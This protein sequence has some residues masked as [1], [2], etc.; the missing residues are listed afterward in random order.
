MTRL[1]P[2]LALL[3]TTLV[4]CDEAECL[5]HCNDHFSQVCGDDE[6]TYDNPCHANCSG[7]TVDYGGPCR[8]DE[9]EEQ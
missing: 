9:P 3:G 4:G 5:A 2:L 1:V 8:G 6:V 7:T